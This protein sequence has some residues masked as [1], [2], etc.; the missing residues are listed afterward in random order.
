MMAQSWS[1]PG[2]EPMQLYNQQFLSAPPNSFRLFI[3]RTLH[4]ALKE[5]A[6][7]T[8]R[9]G[10]RLALIV[11]LLTSGPILAATVAL[12]L[13]VQESRST[14]DATP[15]TPTWVPYPS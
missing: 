6:V 15:Q 5:N 13:M 7:R 3:A 2:I 10:R 14:P 4:E 11:R 1:A 12:G 9:Y 8:A